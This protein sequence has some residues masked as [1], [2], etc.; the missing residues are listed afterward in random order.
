MNYIKLYHDL[1]KKAKTEIRNKGP[2]TYYETHHIKPICLGGSDSKDNLVLLTPKEHYMAHY[3]LYKIYPEVRGIRGGFYGMQMRG[4]SK[5][6]I[7]KAHQYENIRIK[8]IDDFRKRSSWNKGLK[9][10]PQSEESNKKRS[11]TLKEF[12]KDKPGNR[13]GCEPWNK[14]QKTGP[15]WNSGKI[16]PK[17]KCPHCSKEGDISNMKRWHFDNCGKRGPKIERTK[18][19]CPHCGKLGAKSPMT[20]WHFD[21]CKEKAA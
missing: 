21:N 17:V 18:I 5:K 4:S 8:M 19:E 13:K 3:L 16:M 1:I 10:P 12:W 11:E 15:A 9:L 6:R 14:G 2:K 20:R 7:L